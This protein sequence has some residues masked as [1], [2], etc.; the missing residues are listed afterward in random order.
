MPKT[1][2]R[3]GRQDLLKGIEKLPQIVH[4]RGELTEDELRDEMKAINRDR[5]SKLFKSIDG[6][7]TF[8]LLD[9]N[10]SIE[11]L[12]QDNDH[13]ELTDEGL[14]LLSTP[15]FRVAAFHLLERK[16]RTNFTY[17]HTL[18]QELDRK[19]QAGNYDMGTDLADTV[20]TLMKDT[21]S[22]NKVTAGAIACFLRDFEI[23]VENDGEWQLDPA[24]YTYFRG[25]D[26]DI[27]EDIIAEHGNRMDRAELERLL[28]LDFKWTGE[29]VDTIIQQLQDQNRVATDRYE[30]KTVVELVTT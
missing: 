28:T 8:T 13:I 27:V 7:L 14:D 12:K 19:I 5:D 21:V 2:P 15:D 17:F 11:I 22:G 1:I 18:L 20:N 30:G 25:E 3:I 24:Q 6:W 26:K 9:E 29:Q 10:R 16:S 23:V 4:F